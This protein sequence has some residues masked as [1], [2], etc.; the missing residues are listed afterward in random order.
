MAMEQQGGQETKARIWAKIGR[1]A[2]SLLPNRR[3]KKVRQAHKPEQLEEEHAQNNNERRFPDPNKYYQELTERERISPDLNKIIHV[4]RFTDKPE[5]KKDLQRLVGAGLSENAVRKGEISRKDLLT[6]GFVF[7]N[8]IGAGEKP[9]LSQTVIVNGQEVNLTTRRFLTKAELSAV[10]EQ[11]MHA[12]PDSPLPGTPE[13]EDLRKDMLGFLINGIELATHEREMAMNV[14]QTVLRELLAN[15]VITQEQLSKYLGPEQYFVGKTGLKEEYGRK[16]IYDGF[17]SEC[18]V[19]LDLVRFR[20]IPITAMFI[21]FDKLRG[22]PSPFL[23]S[24]FHFDSNWDLTLNTHDAEQTRRVNMVVWHLMSRGIGEAGSS[25]NGSHDQ[26]Y[27]TGA[28]YMRNIYSKRVEDASL[29]KITDEDKKMIALR[30]RVR[31]AR[32]TV[33]KEELEMH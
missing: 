28:E 2:S 26:T 31:V 27:M 22:A 1:A 32:D 23:D 12:Q 24:G 29:G 8:R 14:A 9:I 5:D 4:H 16:I 25:I 33:S 17:L 30:M 6:A 19:G 10:M 15:G 13:M 7:H 21:R 20:G 3:D 11:Q 18:V